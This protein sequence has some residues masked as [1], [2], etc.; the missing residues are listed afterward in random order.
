M[1]IA[2]TAA[3]SAACS[4]C[5]PTRLSLWERYREFLLSRETILVLL[6]ALL[7]LAGLATSVAGAPQVGHW[8]YLAS[9]LVGG[10]PLFVFAAKGLIIHHDITAGVMGSVA[11][12]AAILV[13]QY[14]AA[15]IVV[16]MM[17]VGEWLE[18]LT[19]ARA[20]N[21][22]RDLARL[23][24][25]TVTV[26]RDGARSTIPLEQIVLGDTVLLR[27]GERLA[28]DGL[29]LDGSGSVNQAAI[30]GEAM[31]V[32]K[33][34]GDEVYA[35]TLNEVGA[36]AVRVTRL[37][38][39]TTLGQIIKLVKEAQAS[40]APVQRV[41]NRYA[42]ILVPITFGIALVVY[43]LS[44]DI[45]RAITILVV[46]CPC[47]LILATP[48]AVTAAIGNA[49][50]RGLLVKSGAVIEQVGKVDVVALDKTGTLTRGRPVVTEVISLDGL[51]QDQIL[52]LAAATERAS[53]HP[54]GRSIVRASREGN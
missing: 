39:D 22:L 27:S 6:N 52:A 44:G 54:I 24:P 38:P 28:V 23:I 40:Q 36:L 53:E 16:L 48:T 1:T 13:G 14:S 21:A 51:V 8:L 30:T 25:A 34:A 41:A 20:D 11:M 12:I 19:V 5:Q 7:L 42:R 45:L 37:G 9:A 10:A 17:S 47:A 33:K 50:K 46:V 35:G 2:D 15:A 49:A 3:H 32:E 18:N 31:P 43:L 26:R 4:T 29:V